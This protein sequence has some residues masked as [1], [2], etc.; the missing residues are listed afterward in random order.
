MRRLNRYTIEF[1]HE[2][3]ALLRRSDRSLKEVAGDLGVN[4]WTL[5]SWMEQDDMKRKKRA[6]T[7]SLPTPK[8]ETVEEQLARLKR[9]N[10]KLLRE[11]DQLKEDREILKKAAAF[12][13]KE[14]E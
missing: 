5:R 10:A 11:N 7:G 9:E 3:L 12:F 2:A 6:P 14:S 4:H 8:N 1:R 13:A